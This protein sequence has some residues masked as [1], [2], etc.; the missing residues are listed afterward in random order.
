MSIFAGNS[1][2]HPA[3]TCRLRR[4]RAFAG[5]GRS[6]RQMW[7]LDIPSWAYALPIDATDLPGVFFRPERRWA[8][9]IDDMDLQIAD[10]KSLL[11][12]SRA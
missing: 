1:D 7:P 5:Q 8:T 10:L 11:P 6:P 9:C 2:I 12:G 3:S 4:P